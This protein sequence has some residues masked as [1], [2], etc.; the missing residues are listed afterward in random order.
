MF[1]C[2]FRIKVFKMFH[3]TQRFCAISC[4]NIHTSL[5]LSAIQ[6]QLSEICLVGWFFFMFPNQWYNIESFWLPCAEIVLVGLLHMPPIIAL[7]LFPSC[8]ATKRFSFRDNFLTVMKLT[9]S[10]LFFF[11]CAVNHTFIKNEV[12][13]K[14][15]L[16]TVLVVTIT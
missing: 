10:F 2:T 9:E 8:L 15:F 4:Q 13:C 5:P 12:P 7:V 1:P 16:F 14:M 3:Q 6:I 11:Q